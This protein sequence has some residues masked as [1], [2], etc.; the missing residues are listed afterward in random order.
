ARGKGSLKAMLTSTAGQSQAMIFTTKTFPLAAGVSLWMRFFIRLDRDAIN[1]WT[2]LVMMKD[3]GNGRWRALTYTPPG[4][5]PTTSVFLYWVETQR[6]LLDKK[7]Q[8]PLDT[9]AC[10]EIEARGTNE[11]H[12]YV[13]GAEVPEMTARRWGDQHEVQLGFGVKS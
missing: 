10:W 12:L 2:P 3:V 6:T 11:L 13:N 9:W 5:S 8:P 7:H 4:D 1:H